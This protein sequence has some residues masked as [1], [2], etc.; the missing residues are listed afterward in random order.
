MV[1]IC[2]LQCRDETLLRKAIWVVVKIMIPFWI[3]SI[4]WHL[5]FGIP[6]NRTIMLTIT[7][8]CKKLEK[9]L[10]DKDYSALGSVSLL[11]ENPVCGT[12]AIARTLPATAYVNTG[13]T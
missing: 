10:W 8:I 4:I 12:V 7:P 9:P 1:G 2:L 3:P 11:M 13:N 6:Q 5:I